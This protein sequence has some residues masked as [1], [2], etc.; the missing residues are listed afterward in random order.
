[1]IDAV[2]KALTQMFTPPFRRVLLKAIGL[3]LI[4]I[5]LLGV[6]MYYGFAWLAEIGANWGQ[7]NV[8]VVPQNVWT[9]LVWI[10]SFM[11]SLGIITGAVFLMPAVTAFVG[12]FFVDEIA[13]QVEGIYYPADMPGVALPLFRALLEGV[14]TA[15][16]TIAVYIV[17]L[18]FVLF[19]G[20]GIVILF[21]ANAYL[22]SR[23]YFELAAMR[24]RPPAEAKALRRAHRGQV[25][26]AGLFIAA[27][28]SIPV[29]NL[30][31]PLFAMALMVH[32]HKRLSGRRMEIPEAKVPRLSR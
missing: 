28:V 17:A 14:K 32:L 15:L 24:F 25:F 30:A 29:V 31:T 27:F 5:V 19:A 22:L 8:G 16:L 18:P 4:M 2:V 20:L 9:V 12:S 11:A 13:D 10:L 23:E 1:M 6:G 3:A 7:S 26:F 21:L